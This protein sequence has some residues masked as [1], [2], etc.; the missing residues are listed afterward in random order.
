MK[1]YGV[2][3][4]MHEGGTR[5]EP[6][7]EMYAIRPLGPYGTG[8]Y[9]PMFVTLEAAEDYQ[10]LLKGYVFQQMKVLELELEA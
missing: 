8:N 9:P 4:L 6:V 2:G 3:L 10:K 5:G 1:I 7:A